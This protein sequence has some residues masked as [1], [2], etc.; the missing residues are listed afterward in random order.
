M[1]INHFRKFSLFDSQRSLLFYHPFFFGELLR[2]VF[3]SRP[4][5]D[6]SPSSAVKRDRSLFFP[7]SRQRSRQS[8]RVWCDNQSIRLRV[9]PFTKITAGL[10]VF[11]EILKAGV[12]AHLAN[13]FHT[14]S[15]VLRGKLRH[16]VFETQTLIFIIV[17][18]FFFCF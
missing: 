2:I 3:H 9:A 10:L 18:G 13:N 12:S 11:R 15:L 6:P 4:K 1:Q 7:K 17:T 16:G 5:T 14:F 8:F